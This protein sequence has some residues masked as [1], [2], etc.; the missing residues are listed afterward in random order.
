MVIDVSRAKLDGILAMGTEYT[1]LKQTQARQF[2]AVL[3]VTI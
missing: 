2:V 3:P 1:E